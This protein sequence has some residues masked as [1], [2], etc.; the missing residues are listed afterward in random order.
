MILQQSWT[1]VLVWQGFY[2]VPVIQTQEG[3]LQ[4][5]HWQQHLLLTGGVQGIHLHPDRVSIFHQLFSQVMFQKD[6]LSSGV[7]QQGRMSQVMQS[8]CHK[9]PH[10]HIQALQG[11]W[12][13]SCSLNAALRLVHK[14]GVTSYTGSRT[15]QDQSETH[16]WSDRPES[17]EL[18]F[19]LGH[20]CQN[21]PG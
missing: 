8:K 20:N 13:R 7:H 10:R 1:S 6:L 9:W 3:M 16:C 5:Q 19:H 17:L 11:F 4:M 15:R 21:W 12:M 2:L 14:Q 18:Q